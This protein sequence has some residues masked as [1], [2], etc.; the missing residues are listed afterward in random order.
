MGELL[1]VSAP[2]S[3]SDSRKWIGRIVIA[4]VLG[5]AIW[6]FLVSITNYLVLPAMAKV[7]GGGLSLS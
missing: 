7:I 5:E 1:N 3:S 4:V 2:E 6:G